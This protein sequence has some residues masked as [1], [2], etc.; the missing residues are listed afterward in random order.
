M[1]NRPFSILRMK[2]INFY[3]LWQFLFWVWQKLRDIRL[4]YRWVWGNLVGDIGSTNYVLQKPMGNISDY[5]LPFYA[6]IMYRMN[7]NPYQTIRLNVGYNNIQFN[8]NYAKKITAGRESS[9]EPTLWYL[10]ILF[11]NII[12]FRSMKQVSMISPYIFGGVSGF[13]YEYRQ[14]SFECK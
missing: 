6:G 3:P 10:R 11:L 1:N 5:G 12:F 2:R 7:F 4:G 9:Q 14:S 13:I 8:D